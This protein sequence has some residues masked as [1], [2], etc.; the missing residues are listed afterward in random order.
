MLAMKWKRSTTEFSDKREVPMRARK[1]NL[2]LIAILVAAL[3]LFGQ[4]HAAALYFPGDQEYDSAFS[5]AVQAGEL[6]ISG[7]FPVFGTELGANPNTPLSKPL[8]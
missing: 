5:M 8:K 6:P 2:F 4:D 7:V 1:Q 3:P